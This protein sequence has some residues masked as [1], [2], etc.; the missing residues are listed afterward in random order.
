MK[1][2][3]DD[4]EEVLACGDLQDEV[5]GYSHTLFVLV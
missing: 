5:R 4:V 1:T 3:S 2:S